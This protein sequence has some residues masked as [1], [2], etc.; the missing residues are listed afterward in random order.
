MLTSTAPDG[1]IQETEHLSPR[2]GHYCDIRE[3]AE[4]ILRTEVDFITNASFVRCDHEAEDSI[5]TSS[6]QFDGS[7][8]AAAYPGRLPAHLRD[9]AKP[10][11]LPPRKNEICFEL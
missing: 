1:L 11:C 2:S 5:L 7:D 8:E 9:C 4:A 3:R 6:S 10:A